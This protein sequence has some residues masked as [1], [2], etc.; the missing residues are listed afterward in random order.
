MTRWITLILFS[1]GVLHASGI[2]LP[3]G[4]G[5]DCATMC[6][7]HTKPQ[8]EVVSSC[9]PLGDALTQSQSDDYCPMSGGPC[10]CGVSPDQDHQPTEPMPMPQRDRDTLQMVRA[11][12]V[13]I[14]VIEL[15]TPQRLTAVGMIDAI[16]SGFTHNQLQALLGIWRR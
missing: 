6:A 3:R 8:V 13:G 14:H 9:C 10:T 15:R 12:P 5:D 2:S 7:S 11:P 4:M 1:I 16:R